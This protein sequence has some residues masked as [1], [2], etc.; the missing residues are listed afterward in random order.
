MPHTAVILAAGKGTRMKSDVPKVLHRIAG[1]TMLDWVLAAVTESGPERIIVVVGHG[2]DE[3]IESLPDGI[4]SCL[5]ADQ[6]GTGHAVQVAMEALGP[7]EGDV[8]VLA[9]DTPL[10]DAATISA[11]VNA[12]SSEEN[13]TTV[14]SSIVA[15]PHG[16]GRIVRGDDGAVRAIVEQRDADDA[17][18]SIDE[19]N[20]GAYVFS[21][22]ELSADIA[23]L[24]TDNAQ[25]EFYLTDVVKMATDNG[26]R[27]GAV[28]AE[29]QKVM[30]VNSHRHLAEAAA[31]RRAIINSE[32]M[33]A[34]VAMVDPNVTYVDHDVI[35]EPGA[36]LY[37]NVHLTAGTVVR[38]G[39]RVGPDVS[40]EASTIGA[41]ARVWYSV[42]RGAVVGTAAEVGP[43]G[44]LRPEAVLGESAKAGTFVEIKKSV[45]GA[46]TKI[47]H[48]SYVGDA[49][50]GDRS[51]LG[52]GTVTVNY[53]GYEKFRTE[54]G[55]DV[56]IGSD[57]MLVAPVS[58]GDGAMTAAGSVITEDVEP[59]AMA[60]GR[61]RQVNKAGLAARLRARYR[62]DSGSE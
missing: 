56:K 8:L 5:Q 37:P 1:R 51:N 47:P 23:R 27:V 6:R 39:A 20:A 14:L 52:A 48:L 25:G 9:G 16:Y 19:I 43:Y 28:I 42:I 7:L 32:L 54:I 24:T 15:E 35:V 11:L 26:N 18:D 61:A 31:H 12:H 33:E 53:N 46:G 58:I 17:V 34:G 60:F 45:V 10:L 55:S 13:V 36:T 50:I 44:S 59:G 49:T 41:N 30:G 22:A 57:T 2:A 4:E 3:V 62:G 21:V 29:E 38:A 40:A